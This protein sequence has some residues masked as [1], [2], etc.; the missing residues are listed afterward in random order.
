[1]TKNDIF[2]TEIIL[3]TIAKTNVIWKKYAIFNDCH[4]CNKDKSE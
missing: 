1:M 2:Q 3:Q 4:M